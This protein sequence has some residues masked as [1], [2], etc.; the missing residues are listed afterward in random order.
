[1]LLTCLFSLRAL[2]VFCSHRLFIS[3]VLSATSLVG[4]C[5]EHHYLT[6]LTPPTPRSVM[7]LKGWFSPS[8][9]R[10]LGRSWMFGHQLGCCRGFVEPETT[11]PPHH[12]SFSLEWCHSLG[13]SDCH[14]QGDCVYC[15]LC[16]SHWF[17]CAARS[18]VRGQQSEVSL[19]RHSPSYEGELAGKIHMFYVTTSSE[20]YISHVVTRLLVHISL[21]LSPL[22]LWSFP[23]CT[24]LPT[25]LG[26][27][28]S[29]SAICSLYPP[30]PNYNTSRS[31]TIQHTDLKVQQPLIISSK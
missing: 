5:W 7:E 13:E 24:D 17:H 12:I 16:K 28:Q 19:M 29:V 15:A 3:L 10:P 2:G 6:R 8:C 22:S 1:M 27:L 30:P 31:C 18:K 9:V 25:L 14:C 26:K 4:T 23:A 21:P 20:L 11:P